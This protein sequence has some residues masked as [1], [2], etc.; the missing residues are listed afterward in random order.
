[1]RK[2]LQNFDMWSG[3]TPKGL[4]AKPY[5]TITVNLDTPAI[6]LY[7]AERLPIQVKL[8]MRGQSVMTTSEPAYQDGWRVFV[9]PSRPYNRITS[10]YAPVF[11]NKP[12]GYLDYH[13]VRDGDWQENEGWVVSSKDLRDFL[14]REMT[15]I[16][17]NETEIE[18]YI[19]A[20][21]RAMEEKYMTETNFV[22]YPQFGK[23]VDDSV[24]L[25]VT[26]APDAVYRLWLYFKEAP[27]GKG[28]KPR[29]PKLPKIS[30]KGFHVVELGIVEDHPNEATIMGPTKAKDFEGRLRRHVS[31]LLS[32][33]FGQQVSEAELNINLKD[34]KGRVAKREW[35]TSIKIG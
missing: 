16:G 28:S 27:K 3:W 14:R 31:A 22:I 9:D 33:E 26:P 6:Y 23:I 21:P 17:C 10:Q 24:A 13:A 18:D 2:L 15:A 29:P 5:H 1:M 7:P 8:I 20:V 4:N 11:D 34:D 35:T 30:R 32:Q 25:E 12:Y 19:M